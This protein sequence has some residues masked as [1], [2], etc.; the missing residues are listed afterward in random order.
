[1]NIEF[2]AGIA[3]GLLVGWSLRARRDHR[4]LSAL[5]PLARQIIGDGTTVINHT[6]RSGV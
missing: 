4:L 2:F 5:A 3:A 1:M 6:K